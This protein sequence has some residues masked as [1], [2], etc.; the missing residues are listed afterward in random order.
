MLISVC[1]IAKNAV[2]T[3]DQAMATALALGDEVIIRVDDSSTDNTLAIAKTYAASN[4]NVKVMTYTFVDFGS[5][6]NGLVHEASAEWIFMLDTDETIDEEDIITIR[7]WL[8][9][10]PPKCIYSFPRKNW[11][12]FERNSFRQDH[13][14]DYQMRLFPND[15]VV[16]Y[17]KQKVHEMPDGAPRFRCPHT[18]IHINHFCF[19][20]RTK[21]DW[22]YINHFYKD[23]RE[24]N[25]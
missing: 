11:E 8:L 2:R 4:Q 9:T 25:G 5:A 14:P 17:G 19:A 15:G 6:R 20:I 16:N 7:Q 23:L 1:M 24:K 13:Y 21:E 10:A 22:H 3:L 12:D 18:G